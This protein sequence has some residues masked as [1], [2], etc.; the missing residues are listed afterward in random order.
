MALELGAASRPGRRPPTCEASL[1]SVER[2]MARPDPYRRR[3]ESR[4]REEE[5]S[6]AARG[7]GEERGGGGEGRG[8]GRDA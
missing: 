2:R 5:G 4:S 8:G 3:M 7:G 1:R 6:E